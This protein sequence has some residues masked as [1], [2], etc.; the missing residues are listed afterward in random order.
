MLLKIKTDFHGPLLTIKRLLDT[1]L[2]ETFSNFFKKINR[3]PKHS[4]NGRRKPPNHEAVYQ[5]TIRQ[6]IAGESDYLDD[7][8]YDPIL[9]QPNNGK[10]WSRTT[11][12]WLLVDPR[13]KKPYGK[14]LYIITQNDISEI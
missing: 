5:E 10:Q 4:S 11:L 1:C 9:L 2:F 13:N 14:I 7:L 3:K 8:T 6:M 12:S